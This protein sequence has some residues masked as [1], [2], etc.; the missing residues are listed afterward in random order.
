MVQDD[1]AIVHY[2]LDR[3]YARLKAKEP[4]RILVVGSTS[5][6]AAPIWASR[7]PAAAFKAYPRLLE[8]EMTARLPG[9][10]VVVLDKAVAGQTVP[11]VAAQLDS[12]LLQTRP[13]LVVWEAGT[14]D[15]VK[16]LDVNIFGDVLA[17]GLRR[18]HEQ[19]VDVALIDIQYSPQTDSIYDFRPYLEYLWRVGEAEDVNVL[20]RFDIMRAYTDDGRFDPTTMGAED[21]MKN[22]NFVH[23]CLAKHLAR[24]ILTAAQQQPE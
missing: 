6:V 8:G 3:V 17:D 12:A 14:T 7:G 24:M 1:L 9:L 18:L 5:S 2:P 11:M 15:A 21:Q 23:A 13:D 20:R 22:A 19:D 10:K 16:R 4:L